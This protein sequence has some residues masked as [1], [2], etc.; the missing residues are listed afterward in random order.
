M[1]HVGVCRLVDKPKQIVLGGHY[2]EFARFHIGNI[3]ELSNNIH[4]GYA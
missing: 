1:R 4:K 3:K 2:P